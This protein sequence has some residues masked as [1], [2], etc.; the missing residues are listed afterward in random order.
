[1]LLHE[2]KPGEGARHRRKRVGRGD[3][4]GVG[5]QSG[6]GTKG[7]K[8]RTGGGPRPGF[9]GGQLPLMKRL[10]F[11]RGF[12]NRF[13][14]EYQVVNIARLAELPAGS[15]INP[16]TLRALGAIKQV[17]KPIKLLGNGEIAIALS[18]SGVRLTE[19]ARSKILAAGGS[20]ADPA[21]DTDGESETA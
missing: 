7:Q 8:A 12:H 2:I 19:T 10:P 21:D 11:K 15:E 14:V 5:T 4:T 9:E 16:L 6:K 13:R 1:M 3:A 18:V 20:I 17:A